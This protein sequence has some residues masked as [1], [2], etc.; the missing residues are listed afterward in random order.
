MAGVVNPRHINRIVRC[1]PLAPD[2]V[3]LIPEG[4]YPD[5]S[6]DNLSSDRL[7]LN[8]TEQHWS[9]GIFPALNASPTRVMRSR[10]GQNTAKSRFGE[11]KPLKSLDKL[12]RR[13]LRSNKPGNNLLSV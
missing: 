7:P 11:N 6:F 2:I 13:A 10:I 5:L 3:D 1:A 12:F 8:Y 9:L 4:Q